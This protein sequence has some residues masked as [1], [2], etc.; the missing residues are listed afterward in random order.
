MP[1]GRGRARGRRPAHRGRPP[2]RVGRQEDL[3]GRAPARAVMLV[4]GDREAEQQTVS[5]RR[6]GKVD[7]GSQPLAELRRAG[8][9]SRRSERRT[10][11]PGRWRTFVTAVAKP[12]ERFRIGPVAAVDVAGESTARPSR[13]RAVR[14]TTIAGAPG[15]APRW[16]ASAGSSTAG[17][18]D[19]SA[20]Q[21]SMPYRRRIRSYSDPCASSRRARSGHTASGTQNSREAAAPGRRTARAAP[22]TPGRRD[23]ARAR[24]GPG[25]RRAG[26][27]ASR[28]RAPTARSPGRASVPRTRPGAGGCGRR[29]AA[30]RMCRSGTPI[31]GPATDE[32][33]DR[34][35]GGHPRQAVP[36]RDRPL[37]C[38]A[39]VGPQAADSI[40]RSSS[41]AT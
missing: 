29:A 38:E 28:A 23:R 36:L 26:C 40:A 18:I 34:L 16:R 25:C 12:G 35:A 13:S 10:S 32:E 27:G 21:G 41:A 19:S 37:G 39:I 1:R 33:L 22:S 9:G 17:S 11:E 5:V 6:H 20:V 24:T 3:R 2:Q 14:V 7:L 31:D 4:V 15:R 30:T 8:G